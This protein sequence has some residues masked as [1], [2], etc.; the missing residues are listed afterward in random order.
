[1]SLNGQI[2]RLANKRKLDNISTVCSKISSDTVRAETVVGL[3][4]VV[5]RCA[6]ACGSADMALYHDKEWGVFQDNDQHL[7]EMLILEG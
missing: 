4:P 1:M 2:R 5:S 6:W 3:T 7:F